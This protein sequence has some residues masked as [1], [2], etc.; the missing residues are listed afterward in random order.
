MVYK[1][2]VEL[3]V[4]Q[5]V[6]CSQSYGNNGCVSGTMVA[7]FKYAQAVGI[8][9]WSNY[10]WFG[11]LGSCRCTGGPYKPKG[12][13]NVTS[14]SNMDSAITK[15]PLSV[16]VDGRNFNFYITEGKESFIL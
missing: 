7:S 8:M 12:Y 10:P 5:I 11:T 16:A 9:A 3:S 6:D 14:C 2:Q 1:S 15:Q 4:Q 13:V